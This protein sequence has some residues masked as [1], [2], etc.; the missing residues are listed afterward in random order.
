MAQL[1]SSG[2]Y[3]LGQVQRLYIES[4]GSFTMIE[5][6]EQKPGLTVLPEWDKAIID[7]QPKVSDAFV[8]HIEIDRT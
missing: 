1:R 4:S 7:A 2:L 5:R 3:H 6:K 8:C